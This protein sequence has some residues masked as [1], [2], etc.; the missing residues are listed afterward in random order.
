M[1]REPTHVSLGNKLSLVRSETKQSFVKEQK[2]AH[3]VIMAC[4][5][6]S[7][8]GCCCVDVRFY[9]QELKWHV[10]QERKGF[11][12][13]SWSAREIYNRGYESPHRGETPWD[14]LIEPLLVVR[15]CEK[16]VERLD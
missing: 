7:A 11:A 8:L 14:W 4:A 1:G 2:F 16:N 15:Q 9:T 12:R 3:R 6:H 10:W 5:L 13:Q